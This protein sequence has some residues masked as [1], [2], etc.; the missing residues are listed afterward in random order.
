MTSRGTSGSQSAGG[1]PLDGQAWRDEVEQWRAQYGDPFG[2]GDPNTPHGNACVIEF[3]RSMR[4]PLPAGGEDVARA[5]DARSAGQ[6]ESP[7]VEKKGSTNATGDISKE[8]STWLGQRR[9]D[10]PRV[11]KGS[12]LL[13][14][15]IAHRNRTHI[16]G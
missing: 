15:D 6:A 7:E 9:R 1:S 3:C 11:R 10:A 13:S 14:S 4:L 2:L 8:S 12:A 5:V 16:T